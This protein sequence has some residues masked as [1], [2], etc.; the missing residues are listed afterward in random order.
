MDQFSFH[1]S[2]IIVGSLILLGLALHS[3]WSWY[4][5]TPGKPRLRKSVN[6]HSQRTLLAWLQ[7]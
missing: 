5:N 1:L 2:L 6:P 7:K 3:I 4:K